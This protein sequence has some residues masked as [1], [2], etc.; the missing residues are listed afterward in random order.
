MKLIKYV[1][2]ILVISQNLFAQNKDQ[3]SDKLDIKKLEQ[4]YWSAKDDDFSVVQNRTYTKE[5]RYFLNVSYGFP[6][7]DPYSTGTMTGLTGGYYFS[8]RWGIEGSYTTAT[9][10]NNDATDQFINEHGT[11]PN[12]NILSGLVDVRAMYIPF[13]AKMSFL[14]RKIIYF[15][16]GV[17]L[18]LGNTNYTVTKDTGNVTQTALH[19]S[20]LLTQHFF[21]NEHWAFRVDYLNVWTNEDKYR[22]KIGASEPES[23]RLLGNKSV[24]DTALQVGLTYWH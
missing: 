24:N 18:G 23:A 8:E 15:D 6:V 13:Y 9:Y 20:L 16:M 21:F 17:G 5:N 22:Y 1:V 2:L 14:D 12:H 11:I 10:K 7:N 19:Y 4:K 3:S